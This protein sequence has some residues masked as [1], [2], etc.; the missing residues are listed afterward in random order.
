MNRSR[1]CS[2][3]TIRILQDHLLGWREQAPAPFRT[4]TV[5]DGF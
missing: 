1:Q 2:E 5:V 4:E 3:G